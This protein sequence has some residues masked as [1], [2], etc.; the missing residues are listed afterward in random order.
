MAKPRTTVIFP[1][2]TRRV[3]K[4]IGCRRSARKLTNRMIRHFDSSI[5]FCVLRMR[6][7]RSFQFEIFFLQWIIVA[8]TFI[9]YND[10]VSGEIHSA[11]E[12]RF[13]ICHASISVSIYITHCVNSAVSVT[14]VIRPPKRPTALKET[15]AKRFDMFANPFS[16]H[17]SGSQSPNNDE[18]YQQRNLYG[19]GHGKF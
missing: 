11:P 19:N 10:F 3:S 17:G 8:V 14:E 15:A 5:W 2:F 13:T 18:K 16:I 4:I 7:D 12:A 6:V 1:S 9:G